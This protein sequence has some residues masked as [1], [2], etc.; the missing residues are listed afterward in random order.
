MLSGNYVILP[1]RFLQN[2]QVL[3]L[4]CTNQMDITTNRFSE[5]ITIKANHQNTS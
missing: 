5:I 4:L 1:A 2:K 3:I